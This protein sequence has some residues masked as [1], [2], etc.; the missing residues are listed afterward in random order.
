MPGEFPLNYWGIAGCTAQLSP[1]LP[2]FRLCFRLGRYRACLPTTER[3]DF[4]LLRAAFPLPWIFIFFF[5]LG[6]YQNNLNAISLFLCVD[7]RLD[8]FFF[9]LLSSKQIA[10]CV[11]TRRWLSGECVCLPPLM[12]PPPPFFFLV[13]Y[14]TSGDTNKQVEQ[15]MFLFISSQII[16]SNDGKKI[17]MTMTLAAWVADLS[18]L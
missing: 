11:Y 12:S 15:K 16:H 9:P 1:Y 2:T 14:G 10:S 3:G 13:V 7:V 5:W 17:L 18:Q 8:F 6:E 4:C